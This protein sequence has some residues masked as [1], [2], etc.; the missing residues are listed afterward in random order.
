MSKINEIE[1]K[2]R[3]SVNIQQD[4][5][6]HFKKSNWLWYRDYIRM[7]EKNLNKEIKYDR[8]K[9]QTSKSKEITRN[10]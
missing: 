6:K 7:I 5:I 1:R 10:K 3:M 4:I 9:R 2:I 8:N